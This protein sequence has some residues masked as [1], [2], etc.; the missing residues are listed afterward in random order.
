MKSPDSHFFHSPLIVDDIILNEEESSHLV[1]VCRVQKGT[2]IRLCDGE[3]HFADAMVLDTNPKEC[4]V[5][6]EKVETSPKPKPLFSLALACLKDDG[7][8]E[9]AFHASQTEIN[10]IVFLRTDFSQEPK[11][12][13]CKK[14]IRRAELKSKVSLKQSLKPWLTSIEGPILL[15]DWLS[16]YSGD[17]ILA[18]IHGK[19]DLEPLDEN[20][21]TTLLIGPEGGFS[22]REIELIKSYK[23]GKVHLLN[24]GSTRLRAR[25]AAIIA[26]G[27]CLH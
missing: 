8:E 1:R 20:K 19:S 11:N 18:D 26:L 27:K 14:M 5:F 12:S 3:G 15:D 9:V 17:L 10:Q 7:N 24:L 6:V 2:S 22:N 25:T 16:N 4:H 13:D 23:K 21:E